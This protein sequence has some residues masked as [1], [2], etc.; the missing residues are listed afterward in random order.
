MKREKISVYVLLFF[1][2]IF[3]LNQTT[4]AQS[5]RK[6]AQNASPETTTATAETEITSQQNKKSSDVSAIKI[7]GEI[8]YDSG[9]Q[10]SNYLG[11]ALDECVESLK[12]RPSRPLEVSKSGK[13]KLNDAKEL[14]KKEA[15]AHVLWLGFFVKTYSVGYDYVEYVD[16]ALLKP[17]TGK[18]VMFGRIELGKTNLGNAGTVLQIPTNRRSGSQLLELKQGAREVATILKRGGWLD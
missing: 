8:Q 9:W 16:Y 1:A 15:K 14:A 18:V 12:G 17:E 5:G 3:F 11:H 4:A 2:V 13:M 10:K 7:T 6:P